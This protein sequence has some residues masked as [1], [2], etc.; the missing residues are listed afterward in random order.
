L[1]GCRSD[2][3]AAKR[4]A[5]QRVAARVAINGVSH[6]RHTVT[7]ERHHFV[8]HKLVFAASLQRIFAI[9]LHEMRFGFES[10]R[11]TA[12]DAKQHSTNCDSGANGTVEESHSMFRGSGDLHSSGDVR[13]THL[14]APEAAKNFGS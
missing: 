2:K 7:R 1:D 3:P 8:H 10:R 9:L 4:P 5:N 12:N 11:V 14:V 13:V 6:S